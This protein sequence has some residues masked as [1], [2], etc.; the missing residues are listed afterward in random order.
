MPSDGTADPEINAQDLPED[1]TSEQ[2]PA[3]RPLS[4]R[5]LV[6]QK[7]AQGRRNRP[8][9]IGG[10]LIFLAILSVPIYGF[11]SEFVLPSRQVAVQVN[12]VTYTRGD[13]VDFVRFH[14]RL[15]LEAGDEFRITDQ[16][17]TALE[18]ISENEIAYQKAP[19]LGI[20]V[21]EEEV[22][23]AIRETI[24]FSGLSASMAAESG[25]RSDIAE[26]FRQLLNRIQLSEKAYTEIIR[27]S[28]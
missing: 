10:V 21:T 18:T 15:A 3:A 6:A 8:F 23:G 22:Q 16:L 28:L 9:I 4:R 20:T 14:Q 19:L 13:I 25:V 26:S 12:D 11:V 7:Q 27:K 1:L 2:R 24:G 17:L 5:E